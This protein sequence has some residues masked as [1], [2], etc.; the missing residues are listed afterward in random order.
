MVMEAGSNG[1]LGARI[2]KVDS[3]GQES[4]LGM[5][6]FMACRVLSE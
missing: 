2:L 3:D 5:S 4:L 1:S 6:S